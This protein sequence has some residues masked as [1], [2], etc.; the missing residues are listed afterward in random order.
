MNTF[1]SIAGSAL[2]CSGAI[3][4]CTPEWIANGGLPPSQATITQL[5]AA[6]HSDGPLFL[7]SDARA[8]GLQ[9]IGPS[10]YSRGD[11]LVGQTWHRAIDRVT[12]LSQLSLIGVNSWIHSNAH[13]YVLGQSSASPVMSR[14]NGNTLASLPPLSN[15]ASI[16]VGDSLQGDRLFAQVYVDQQ[17]R[18]PVRLFTL[19]GDIWQ[20]INIQGATPDE[21]RRFTFLDD[22]HG[23]K[24]VTLRTVNSIPGVHALTENGWSLLGE[25]Q[26]RAPQPNSPTQTILFAAG[27][28]V[29]STL[30]VSGW[31]DGIGGTHV[32]NFGGY[33]NGQWF[34]PGDGLEIPATNISYNR[35]DRTASNIAIISQD[36]VGS[37]TERR[38]GGHRVRLLTPN[39]W[40]PITPPFVTNG[41]P[42]CTGSCIAPLH[43]T[44]SQNAL[45]V[46]GMFSSLTGGE[47]QHSLAKWN[48]QA[49][50]GLGP[51]TTAG[52]VTDIV[53]A[54]LGNG[55]EMLVAGNFYHNAPG[56]F[57]NLVRAS[58]E[59][60]QSVGNVESGLI[61]GYANGIAALHVFSNDSGA[62]LLRG[63]VG[64]PTIRRLNGTSWA[65][66]ATSP[67]GTSTVGFAQATF[68]DARLVYSLNK[69]VSPALWV[70]NGNNWSGVATPAARVPSIPRAMRT[71]DSGTGDTLFITGST[72]ST[73]PN[74]VHRYDGVA[75]TSASEG[76]PA[77]R[78]ESAF[79]GGVCFGDLNVDS[80]SRLVIGGDFTPA[81]GTTAA[82]YLAWW[83]GS[84][85]NQFEPAPPS[86]VLDVTMHDFG[87]GPIPVA[88]IGLG[89][90]NAPSTYD[91]MVNMRPYRLINGS[92][93]PFAEVTPLPN[94]QGG[95]ISLASQYFPQGVLRSINGTLWM[96]GP[97]CAVDGK[98]S[99]FLAQYRCQCTAD[100][101]KDSALD[102]FDYLD[103]VD[104]FSADDV[105]S[106][107]NADGVVDFF[108]YLDFVDRFAAGC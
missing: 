89:N 38:G 86:C 30:Y 44:A 87:Q 46:G 105:S 23:G 70:L 19:H 21:L 74:I 32:K 92:W 47:N 83:N 96:G 58:A 61:D 27:I 60:W 107:I 15:V 26:T 106:D 69:S 13:S 3:A 43:M 41:G 42:N 93:Q 62:T 50:I 11:V 2:L 75:W 77:F 91:R 25:I 73:V 45:Y 81:T 64:F 31:I 8:A 51:L 103:F 29:E 22:A 94:I 17:T 56:R 63:Q 97:F 54:D 53:E 84:R 14:W 16:F 37:P 59:G 104:Q 100:F 102:F 52:T 18:T 95:S 71:V 99:Y 78:T 76:L 10:S 12:G 80:V 40:T 88:L 7:L 33:R 79:S 65:N 57:K 90:N 48:G 35:G 82:R 20:E 55:P 34:N 6:H 85:W 5:G 9:T 28:G 72:S 68:N 24:L 36:A 1:L 49:W 108:D 39:G 66:F 67:P 98:P 4:Q 101:N